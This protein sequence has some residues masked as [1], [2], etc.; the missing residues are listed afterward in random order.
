MYANGPHK[1]I[2]DH[3]KNSKQSRR[4]APTDRLPTSSNA[5]NN[6]SASR[7]AK[8]DDVSLLVFV[9]ACSHQLLWRTTEQRKDASSDRQRTDQPIPTSRKI[10]R[11]RNAR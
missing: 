9:F 4:H 6:S 8:R 5:Y 7:E 1:I 10:E 11:E 3:D 2:A